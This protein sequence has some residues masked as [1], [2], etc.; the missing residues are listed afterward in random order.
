[1]PSIS[2]MID[3]ISKLESSYIT[4]H[5]ER[6][7]LVRNRN[8]DCLRCAEVCTSGCIHYNNGKLIVSPDKCIGCGTCAT[9]CPTCALEAH[10]PDD[11]QLTHQ[12]LTAAQASEGTVCLACKNLLSRVKGAYDPEKVVDVECLGRVEESLLTLLAAANVTEVVLVHGACESC[13]HA[14]GWNMVQRVCETEQHLLQAWNSSMNIRALAKLPAHTRSKES[15]VDTQKRALFKQGKNKMATLGIAAADTAIQNTLQNNQPE[16]TPAPPLKVMKD[17]TLPHFLPDRREHLLNAL[18]SMG[19]PQDVMLSTRLWGH[20]IIDSE[21]CTSCQMCATFCPTGAISKFQDENGTFGVEH[22][23]GD[24]VKC[25]CCTTICPADALE[26]SEEVFAIDMLAGM[27]DRYEM[28]PVAV[29]RGKSH[30][31]WNL[32]KTMIHTDQVYER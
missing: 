8:A 9:A 32:A 1:M 14:P 27:T 18:A 10:H 17:G 21:R 4:V 28:K 11:A 22:Y 13:K 20:V 3:L 31:I 19:D 24:C 29:E 25:R 15:G 23:P 6:C 5:Q 12:C 30:T 2:D 26:L 16:K 7:V